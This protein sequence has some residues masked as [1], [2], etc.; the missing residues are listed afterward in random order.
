VKRF[1][2]LTDSG[3]R[4]GRN[5]TSPQNPNQTHPRYYVDKFPELLELIESQA[6]K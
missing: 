5:E 2:S 4:F 1:K 6:K 3:L